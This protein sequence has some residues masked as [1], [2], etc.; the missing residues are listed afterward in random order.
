MKTGKTLREGGYQLQSKRD[1]KAGSIV[2]SL[3]FLDA[4]GFYSIM[5][6]SPV[7]IPKDK[8]DSATSEPWLIIFDE[9]LKLNDQNHVLEAWRVSTSS[10]GSL[11]RIPGMLK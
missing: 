10:V 6:I 5:S 11:L 8:P 2:P 7:K 3:I 9:H 1:I 4:S